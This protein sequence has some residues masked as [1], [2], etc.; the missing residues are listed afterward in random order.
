[1][2]VVVMAVSGA[3]NNGALKMRDKPDYH[4]SKRPRSTP[5]FSALFN[6]G[7]RPMPTNVMTSNQTDPGPRSRPRPP[8][9]PL[10]AS[11]GAAGPGR[12]A[13]GRVGYLNRAA[14]V[15]G[16]TSGPRRL[17]PP[18]TPERGP[19][20]VIP[21]H[22]PSARSAPQDGESTGGR[23]PRPRRWYHKA[24]G[25]RELS[26]DPARTRSAQWGPPQSARNAFEGR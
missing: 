9:R 12:P 14:P 23:D 13:G 6:P 1:M 25:R 5:V 18:L 10:I 19:Q 21:Q 24:P 3:G 17:V 7:Q 20:I 26:L 16:E 2:V 4:A 8:G 11:H 22:G 15:A